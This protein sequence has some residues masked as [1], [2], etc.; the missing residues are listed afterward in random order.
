MRQLKPNKNNKFYIG[1]KTLYTDAVTG[2]TAYGTITYLRNG[3]NFLYA[4]IE[5]EEGTTTILRIA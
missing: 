1:M 5:R 2:R 3:M 4:S